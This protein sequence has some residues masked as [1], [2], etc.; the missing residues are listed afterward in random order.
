MATDIEKAMSA[1][2]T[3]I[4]AMMNRVKWKTYEATEPVPQG[5]LH[6]THE[7]ILDFGG[8]VKIR[9]YQLSDGQRV[10]DAEDCYEFF[11]MPLPE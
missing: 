1:H 11:G 6:A 7:G 10:L 4:N 2:D 9:C 5:E 8:D 3:A